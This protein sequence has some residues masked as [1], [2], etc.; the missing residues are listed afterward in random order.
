MLL[1]SITSMSSAQAEGQSCGQVEWRMSI[2]ACWFMTRQVTSNAGVAEG[3]Y[4]AIPR[5]KPQQSHALCAE[6]SA[7]IGMDRLP[8]DIARGR[9]AEEPHHGRDVLRPATG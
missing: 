3:I 6:V 9:A 5:R 1:P 4:P 2:L 8:V 7:A